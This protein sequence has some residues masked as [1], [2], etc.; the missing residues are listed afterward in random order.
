MKFHDFSPF[1]R[2]N[3]GIKPKV[4]GDRLLDNRLVADLQ[5]GASFKFDGSNDVVAIAHSTALEPLLGGFAASCWFKTSMA[6]NVQVPLLDKRQP[7]YEPG[8]NFYLSDANTFVSSIEDSGGSL[9]DAES[10]VVSAK[11][12]KWHHAMMTFS[13]GSTNT[14]NFYLDGVNVGTKTTAN[15]QG[16]VTNSSVPLNI[17]RF[18]DSSGIVKW[19][20]GEIRQVRI[21]NRALSAD[22]VRAAYNGQAVPSE[23]TGASQTGLVTGNDSDMDAVG[24]WT[25]VG[26]ATQTGGYNASSGWTGHTTTLRIEAGDGS[27]EGARIAT[28]SLTQGKRYR[29]KLDYKTINSDGGLANHGLW[30]TDDGYSNTIAISSVPLSSGGTEGFTTDFTWTNPTGTGQL[31]VMCIPTDDYGF[32]TTGGAANELLIDNLTLTQIGCVA[33]YLPT[34]ISS[35]K[36]INSSGTSGLD[37]TVTSATAVNHEVG[38]LTMVDNIVMASGKGIDFSATSDGTTK[39]AEIFTDY[40]EGTWSATDGTGVGLSFTNQFS[41]TRIGNRV[42]VSGYLSIPTNTDGTANQVSGLPFDVNNSNR[43]PGLTLSLH[44]ANTGISSVHA[45]KDTNDFKFVNAAGGTMTWAD[46][47]GKDVYISGHYR[48]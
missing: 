12:G 5:S 22:E 6:S 36:W 38:S 35:T 15:V 41:Y 1:Y 27:N 18:E 46:L 7:T 20:D 40:E 10:S 2:S 14:V 9:F 31:Y 17:G 44:Y 25:V 37:G 42:L 4:S 48:V 3:E 29:L 26:S 30:I 13:R 34:G 32:A 8:W 11:D 23:Y 21:H 39:E 47:S 16:S 33:E 24:N 28:G 43:S 19:M 45:I